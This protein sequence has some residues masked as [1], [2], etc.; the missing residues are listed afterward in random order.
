MRHAS[1]LRDECGPV[2]IHW[3]Y[4]MALLAAA[5]VLAYPDL[6]Y[7]LRRAAAGLTLDLG[8]TWR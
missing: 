2:S 6:G 1:L 7:D 4:V 8:L 3:L 5:A